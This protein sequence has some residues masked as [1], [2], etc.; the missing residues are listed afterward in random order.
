M[1]TYNALSRLKW[2]FEQGKEFKPNETDIEAF[3]EIL[4]YYS[5][6]QE[7]QFEA[8]ELFAKLY[9]YIFMR[10]LENDKSTVFDNNARKKIGNILV[11]PLPQIIDELK[12]SL[13]R[14][15]QY[16]FLNDLG[17]DLEK[18]PALSSREETQKEVD[19]IISQMKKEGP[20]RIR[21]DVW[22]YE[23]VKN[24]VIP[25]VNQMINLYR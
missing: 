2:R 18:H 3:N 24:A 19:K 22:D 10:I 20:S 13:N 14:S 5:D 11:R 17:I 8:N 16:C 21:G 9:L 12:D 15:E 6:T 25:E 1:N 7:K 23:T 4:K